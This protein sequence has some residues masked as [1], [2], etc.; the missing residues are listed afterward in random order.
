MDLHESR[1]RDYQKRREATWIAVTG[2]G[3]LAPGRLAMDEQRERIMT[4][5]AHR[6]LLA[7]WAEAGEQERP[8]LNARHCL[9]D[10]L[11]L[12]PARLHHICRRRAAIV[13]LR[14]SSSG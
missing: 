6:R 10:V 7:P 13:E 5:A 9:N 11:M 2:Y 4:E 3:H 14:R 12:I 1:G 8:P